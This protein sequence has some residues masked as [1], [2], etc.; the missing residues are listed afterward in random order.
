MS[1][2]SVAIFGTD[3]IILKIYEISM[4]SCGKKFISDFAKISQ[5][6]EK[7]ILRQAHKHR[8]TALTYLPLFFLSLN[9]LF[10]EAVS[11]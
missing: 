10:N 3:R 6:A 5:M 8:N 7:L 4:T 1:L 2:P 9:V 11:F